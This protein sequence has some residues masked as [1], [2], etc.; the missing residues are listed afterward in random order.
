MK[1]DGI[2][3]IAVY[4]K[5]KVRAGIKKYH[6]HK[7]MVRSDKGIKQRKMSSVNKRMLAYARR[8]LYKG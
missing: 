8:C 5:A 3:E 6:I 2:R 7:R 4:N 1:L